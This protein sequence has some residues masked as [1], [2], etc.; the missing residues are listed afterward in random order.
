MIY[1]I[2]EPYIFKIKRRVN[3]IE[4]ALSYFDLE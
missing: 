2:R 3:Y 4:M 1:E